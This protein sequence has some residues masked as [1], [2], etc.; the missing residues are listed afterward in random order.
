MRYFMRLLILTIFIGS[1]SFL[2]VSH[3]EA[4]GERSVEEERGPASPQEREMKR[5]RDREPAS[6]Q[7]RE[8]DYDKDRYDKEKKDDEDEEIKKLHRPRHQTY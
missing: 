8:Y 7:D 1:L 5:D 4:R 6:P 3:A 2:M